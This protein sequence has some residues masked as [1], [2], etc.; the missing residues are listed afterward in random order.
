MFGGALNLPNFIVD[1]LCATL[2][3]VRYETKSSRFP[4]IAIT[5]I[6]TQIILT[7]I[8]VV[9]YVNGEISDLQQTIIFTCLC[10]FSAVV[11]SI[12]PTMTKKI[13]DY[14]M[15]KHSSVSLRYQSMENVRVARL[16]NI[17][18]VLYATFYISET[19]LYYIYFY[20][21]KD[22]LLNKIFMSTYIM[23]IAVEVFV[24]IMV[25]TH[26]HPKLSSAL[27]QRKTKVL[28]NC[29]RN[30]VATDGRV[31]SFS[32]DEEQKIYFDSYLTMWKK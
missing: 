22:Y 28:T 4:L 8:C 2:W 30:V 23:S 6:F 31:L 18:M 9:A 5:M 14:H 24:S 10:V 15:K 21:V 19:G 25:M 26:S 27:P 13:N 3:P 17:L 16:L 7:A 11:F 1:R 20:F 32:A 29:S 12:L